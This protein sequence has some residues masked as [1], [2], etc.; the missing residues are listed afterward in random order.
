LNAYYRACKWVL[1]TSSHGD[2]LGQKLYWLT[3]RYSPQEL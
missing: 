3:L 1:T 2:S